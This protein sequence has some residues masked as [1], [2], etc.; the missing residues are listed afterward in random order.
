MEARDLHLSNVPPG[1]R[2]PAYSMR[3]LGRRNLPET[4]II[5][6]TPWTLTRTHKHDFWAVTGFYQNGAGGRAVLK[7]GRTEPFCGFPMEWTGRFLCRREMRFYQQLNDLPNVPKIL[8]RVGKTGFVHEYAEGEPLSRERPVP[9]GF[10]DRLLDLMD[11]LH[12]RG[13]AYVD[14]NKP[15]NIL[16]G[17]DGLPH[18]IDF[19]ISFDVREF[20][21]N[22]VTRWLL[23]RMHSA[24]VYHVLKHKKRMRPDEMTADQWRRVRERGTLIRL[25]RIVTKPYFKFRRTTFKRLRETGRLLPEGSK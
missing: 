2:A 25:H 8:G 23:A 10:F 1:K 12:R 19:Q 11:K 21:D 20:G 6:Q 16:L 7:M 9:D 13:L 3:A 14:A 4:L 5:N 24:D 17:T 22:F 15:Q 18:L